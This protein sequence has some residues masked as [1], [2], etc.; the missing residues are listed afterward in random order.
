LTP[1][2]SAIVVNHRSAAEAADCVASLRV[3]LER[4]GIAGEIVLVDCGSGE[5]DAERLRRVAA[6]ALVLLPEN[7]GY[8]GGVNAGLERARGA[9]LLLCNADVVFRPGSV[10]ELAS[11]AGERRVGAAAPL[12]L[13]D[14]AGRLRLPADPPSG[15]AAELGWTRFAPFARRTLELWERGGDARR[16]VG[17]V[18]A[19][20]REVLDR[21]GAFDERYPFEYEETDWEIRVRRAGLALRFHPAARVRHLYAR[22]A[23]RNPDTDARRA[24][25]RRVFRARHYGPL[26]RALIERSESR[27][28]RPPR[29]T[30]LREPIVPAT[31]GAWVAV[32]TNPTLVPFAGAP[33]D[34]DFRLPD[35]VLASLRRGPVWLRAFRASDGVPLATYVWERP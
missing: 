19:V 28:A 23:A 32:S 12:C 15:L 13:W 2:V 11:A 16:L 29:A 3:E 8:S 25:S 34:E 20:R 18:L 27:P 1:A 7:R 10:A 26:G 17:A 22:S 4:G 30:P 14:E 33:L 6:D 21:V 24:E 9:T 31:T 35:D 5:E